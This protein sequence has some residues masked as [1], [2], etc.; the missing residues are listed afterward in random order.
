MLN[1]NNQRFNLK[2]LLQL[3]Y[4]NEIYFSLFHQS[5]ENFRNL[6]CVPLFNISTLINNLELKE[7]RKKKNLSNA[8]KNGLRQKNCQ[9][10]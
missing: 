10:Y 4:N 8:M 6:R 2:R 9:G 5:D 1:H 3:H 7:R